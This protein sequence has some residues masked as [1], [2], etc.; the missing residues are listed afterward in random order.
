MC[1]MK[2]QKPFIPDMHGTSYTRI[3]DCS[4]LDIDMFSEVS[5]F[6]V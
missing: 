1:K 4:Q 5:L 3:E 6:M 2:W